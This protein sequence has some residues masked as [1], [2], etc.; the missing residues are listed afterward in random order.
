VVIELFG[1]RFVVDAAGFFTVSLIYGIV[2]WQRISIP[3]NQGSDLHVHIEYAK[4]ISSVFDIVSPHFLFQLLL[5]GF[6]HVAPLSYEVAAAAILGMCY[7]G[8]G[9]LLAA[10]LRRSRTLFPWAWATALL[11]ASH[12]FLPTLFTPNFYYGYFSPTAY[13]SASQQLNKLFALAIWF[14]W[15]HRFIYD[16]PTLRSSIG[17]AAACVASAIAKPS[18]LIGF[19]PVSGLFAASRLILQRDT[20]AAM[21]YLWAI[22]V[23]SFMPLFVQAL[24]TYG[25]EGTQI[26]FA[27]FAVF[28]SPRSVVLRLPFTLIFPL[29]VTV[30]YGFKPRLMAAWLFFAV[31]IAYSFLL[32]E[33]GPRTRQG[34]FAWTAQ[35][36]VFLLYVEAGLILASRFSRIAFATFA[37]HTTFGLI[38]LVANATLP[39]A[40]YAYHPEIEIRPRSTIP[41]IVIAGNV[42]DGSRTAHPS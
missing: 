37:L 2:F 38:F 17:M 42:S 31:G 12:V 15:W 33:S 30:I 34:N 21:I 28:E 32:A 7:G 22:A 19:L 26:I 4:S 36:G 23:P 40:R 8:M 41:F 29:T 9:L 27:P 10:E 5:I 6:V 3:E 11:V 16:A 35:T 14:L 13:H 1:R 24:T 20:A 25:G 39:A 18:F